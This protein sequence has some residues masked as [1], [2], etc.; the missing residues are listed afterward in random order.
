MLALYHQE[1]LLL[2]LLLPAPVVIFIMYLRWRR[3]IVLK[4]GNQHLVIKLLQGYSRSMQIIQ[5]I[6]L[7]LAMFFL[8]IAIADPRISAESKQSQVISKNLIFLVDVSLSM[9][10]EDVAPSRLEKAKYII[11]KTL[12]ELTQTKV[13]VVLFSGISFPL[14]PLTYDYSSI[15]NSIA[16]IRADILPV[17]G[18]SMGEALKIP[19]MMH[20]TTDTDKNI[21][22]LISDGENL[23]SNIDALV[24][25]AAMIGTRIYTIGMGT[26]RGSTIPERIQ[27]GSMVL[28]TDSSGSPVKTYLR[29][30]VL[31]RIANRTGAQYMPMHSTTETVEF[32][33]NSITLNRTAKEYTS[34][35]Y[36]QP[37]FQWLI[38]A[39]LLFLVFELVVIKT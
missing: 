10:A 27:N 38:A 9:N 6:L 31:Q 35:Y 3:S 33:Y 30:D 18:S 19:I 32:I 28:K 7:L 26:K 25:S 1:Y 23:E 37:L 8:I 20:D 15:H 12:E 29:D 21:F 36:H 16:G 11:L 2:L 17:P 13:S 5:F 4:L 39:T 22:I 14:V 24:D 34:G